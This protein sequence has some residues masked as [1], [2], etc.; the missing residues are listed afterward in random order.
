MAHDYRELTTRLAEFAQHADVSGE[1][2]G[3]S[4][5]LLGEFGCWRWM[6]PAEYDG[7]GCRPSELVAGYE[8]LSR[9]CMSTA[10]IFTQHDAAVD[11]IVTGSND[12][13]KRRLCP[14]LA[15]GEQ[16]LTVGLSQLTTSHQG[17]DPVMRATWDGRVARFNGLMPWVTSATEADAVVT[18]GVLPDG[19]QI[20]V[21]VPTDAA[22]LRVDPAMELAALQATMTAA[23]HCE[24]VSVAASDVIR[25]PVPRVLA[26]RGT[27]RPMVVSATGLGLAGAMVSSI[28]ETA[29]RRSPELRPFA[30]ALVDQYKAVHRDLHGA[31]DLLGDPASGGSTAEIR[32]AVNDLVMR[33]AI[34]LMTFA[35]GSG[36]LKSHPAQRMAREALFFLVW[37]APDAVQVRTLQKIFAARGGQV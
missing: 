9:G 21:Y 18:G 22:G 4:I 3:E 10:L 31:A 14:A 12:G 33:L 5:D 37:S 6:I 1:W 35:K 28:E 24:D 30:E 15:A 17:G 36:Y 13:L 23:V 2:P 34:G 8:A 11:L 25:G 26:I 32:A 27:V 29:P 16:L 20:A 19:Q 7:D